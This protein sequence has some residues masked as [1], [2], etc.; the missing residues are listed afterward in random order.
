LF[1]PFQTDN[2]LIVQKIS[3]DGSENWH[4]QI[5]RFAGS[6]TSLPDDHYLSI[7]L[8]QFDPSGRYAVMFISEVEQSVPLP[9]LLDLNSC[10][11]TT[12]AQ[13]PL[14]GLPVWSP[15][16]E[17]TIL[18]NAS[19]TE[20]STYLR[21]D[22]MMILD[23]SLQPGVN[24]MW[25]G[26]S[27][28]QL[29]GAAADAP[30]IAEGYSPFWVGNDT[31]GYIHLAPGDKSEVVTRSLSGEEAAVR[32]TTDDLEAL[33]SDDN[34]APIKLRYVMTHPAQP[35]LLMVVAL[36]E[37]AREAYVFSYNLETDEL[38][39][40]LQSLIQPY[41]SLG[42]SPNGRYLV[43]TGVVDNAQGDASIIYVHDL[44]TFETQTYFSEYVRFGFSP[45]Y[46]WSADGNW[47]LFQVDE[48]VLSLT[49]P[50]YQYQRVQA[51]DQGYCTSMAWIN[52]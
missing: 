36:N 17:K 2:G 12:C 30:V 44:D 45:M 41:H 19:I 22:M 38:K 43:L 1:N 33:L 39:L 27:Q 21:N 14:A 9:H 28:G 49:A 24:K 37:F 47:L 29:P 10:D 23:A 52:R 40:R 46:D 4:T 20:S 16:G 31:F 5:W 25:L 48:R 11:E 13:K 50:A 35:D 3:L 26:D 32:V 7:S 6:D 8:G 34:R 42:F 18:V 51:H 15:D